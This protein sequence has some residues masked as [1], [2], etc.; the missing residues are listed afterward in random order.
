MR[1]MIKKLLVLLIFN[2]L[3]ICAQSKPVAFING[4]AHIGNGKVLTSA[5]VVIRGQKIEM[6]ED[7]RGMKL[8]YK[9]FD[10]VIDLAGKHIYPGL[11]NTNNVLGLHDA[12]AVRATVDF[13]EVGALNSHVRSLIAYNTDNI[14][15]PTV[16]TNGV[17]YTQVTPRGNL[18][19]GSSSVMALDGW[20]WE[21]AVLLADDGI[22]VN[23]PR[24]PSY[25]YEEERRNKEMQKHY[26][27]EVLRLSRFFTDAAAYLK[28]KNAA[29]KN[30]RFEAMRAVLTGKSNLYLHADRAAD[31]QAALNFAEEKQITK[32]VLV[33]GRDAWQLTTLLKKRNVPV[34]LNR[35]FDLPD[36][37]DEDIDLLYRVPYLLQKDSVL[38]C[39]QLEGDMEAMHSRNLPFNAGATV[40]Y[41]LDKEQ[42]LAAISLNAAKILGLADRIGS[43]EAGKMASFVISSGD[44]LD[45]RSSLVEAVHIAGKKIDLNNHQS[46]LYNKYKL[47]YGS[48]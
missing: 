35:V 44:L 23:F 29:E 22:H 33:G 16:R 46:D 21:D 37:Q 7:I 45:M 14:I 43:L 31:I 40:A 26:E 13:V 41:G 3:L 10:T 6:V 8:D 4:T 17:L 25:R 1:N 24:H 19:S 48:K 5:I 20:N 30:I 9:S 34:M 36:R 28:Q 12:E 39:L 18:I 32:P 11:I 38:F 15:I 42:A 27:E 2:T 47:K